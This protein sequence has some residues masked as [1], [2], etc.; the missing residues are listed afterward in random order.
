VVRTGFEAVIRKQFADPMPAFLAFGTDTM[1][2]MAAFTFDD[3]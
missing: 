1:G 2:K 3:P